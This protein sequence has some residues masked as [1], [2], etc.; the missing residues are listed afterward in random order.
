VQN[1]AAPVPQAFGVA[2]GQPQTPVV[3]VCPAGQTFPQVPQL[4]ASVVVVAQ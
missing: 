1:A 2:A 4:L 3:Q